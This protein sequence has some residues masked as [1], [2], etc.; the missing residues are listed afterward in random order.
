[1]ECDRL[2]IVQIIPMNMLIVNTVQLPVHLIYSV[3][4]MVIVFI[5]MKSVM[6]TMIVL[7]RRMRKIVLNELIV[8]LIKFAVDHPMYPT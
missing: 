4:L 7:T 2:L 6:V 1:M 3:A 5:Q 8:H